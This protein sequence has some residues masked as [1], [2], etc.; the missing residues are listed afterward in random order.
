M[1]NSFIIRKFL[2]TIFRYT[3]LTIAAVLLLTNGPVEIVTA[4][5]SAKEEINTIKEPEELYARSAVLMDADSGRILFEK[6]GY[7]VMPMASTTKI[8]TLIVALENCNP[9]DVV[10]VSSYA[11][12]QP[13][14]HLGVHTGQQFVLNDLFYSLMLF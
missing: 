2:K 1:K 9:Q 10:T 4:E 13:K 12:S 3:V 7:Q 11:A 14:V 8:M 6:D 5:Q